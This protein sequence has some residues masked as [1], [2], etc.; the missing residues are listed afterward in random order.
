MWLGL[1]RT[2][3]GDEV[4]AAE[5]HFLEQR[6]FMATSAERY[7]YGAEHEA[8]RIAA[9]LRTLF[10]Q[11][12]NSSALFP[13]LPVA[14]NCTFLDSAGELDPGNRMTSANLT[15]IVFRPSGPTF[16]P[17]FVGGTDGNDWLVSPNL[18][19]TSLVGTTD[20]R[21]AGERIEF[22]EWWGMS[23]IKDGE[24]RVFSRQDLVLKVA[25]KDGG[26]HVDPR[27]PRN[28]ADLTRGNSLNWFVQEGGKRSGPPK[29]NPA[30]ASI[31]QIA[32]EVEQTLT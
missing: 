25:N 26:A 5:Q 9:I 19:Q 22:A 14:Q 20:L 24:G 31:R 27:L 13:R 3:N 8:K 7:D 16:V 23:V 12:A 28:Y 1:E 21:P 29:G 4:A 30:L 32:Y 11:T 17:R 15:A 18:K 10:H 6:D 2:V